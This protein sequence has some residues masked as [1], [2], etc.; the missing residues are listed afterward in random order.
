MVLFTA[1]RLDLGI[2]FISS[3]SRIATGQLTTREREDVCYVCSGSSLLTKPPGCNYGDPTLSSFLILIGSKA[4][5]VDEHHFPLSEYFTVGI[6]SEHRDL[7]EIHSVPLYS[8]AMCV[9]LGWLGMAQYS[10]LE[11]GAVWGGHVSN[12]VIFFPLVLPL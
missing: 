10:T 2:A 3:K 8:T 1:K 7:W 11:H 12:Q 6:K 9:W 5:E 4:L